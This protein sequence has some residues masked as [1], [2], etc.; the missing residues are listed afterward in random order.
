MTNLSRRPTIISPTGH[1]RSYAFRRF[2][3]L[4]LAGSVLAFVA[5][6]INTVCVI[7]LFQTPLAAATGTTSRMI[8]GLVKGNFD[9][10]LHLFL[11][12]FSY[13]LGSSISG[14]LIGGS[15]FSIQRW[16]GLVLLLESSALACSYLFEVSKTNF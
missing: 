1:I 9:T 7:N 14:A 13:A 8:V 12:I 16:Y 3:A 15:S 10:A 2:L 6:Y 5:G 4:I 11:I